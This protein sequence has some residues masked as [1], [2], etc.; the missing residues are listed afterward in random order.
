M[1][2]M[3]TIVLLKV[4]FTCATPRAGGAFFSF[5]RGFFLDDFSH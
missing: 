4:D 2:V 5:L 3:V 1:S